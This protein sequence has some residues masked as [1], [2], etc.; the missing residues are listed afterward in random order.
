MSKPTPWE[1]V[2]HDEAHVASNGD[3][4][5]ILLDT[6]GRL[7]ARRG[8]KSVGVGG[9]AAEV[10]L[11]KINELAGEIVQRPGMPAAELRERLSALAGLA[12]VPPPQHVEW[13]VAELDGVRV[14]CNGPEIVVTRRDLT[15]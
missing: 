2:R 6:D 3:A 7:F 9:C 4:R 14:Y 5:V 15:P 13:A 1:F 10:V 8:V 11:P 12:H